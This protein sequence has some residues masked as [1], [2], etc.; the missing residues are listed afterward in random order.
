MLNARGCVFLFRLRGQHEHEATL[1]PIFPSYFFVLRP[2]FRG[3]FL[4]TEG[5]RLP[6]PLARPPSCFFGYGGVASSFSA[7]AAPAS[8]PAP[9]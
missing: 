7:G 2:I 3:D 8:Q 4:G 1:R 9:A 6:F 5:L